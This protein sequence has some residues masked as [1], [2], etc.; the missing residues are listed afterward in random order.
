M[1]TV[2][3][4]AAFPNLKHVELYE[5]G[6]TRE[7]IV[8]LRGARPKTGVY[9][10]PE[11]MATKNKNTDNGPSVGATNAIETRTIEGSILAPIEQRLADAKMV[12][13]GFSC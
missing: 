10:A 1:T 7:G 13:C 3:F 2:E 4:I 5:T 12:P 8:K 11:V 9:V 6:F